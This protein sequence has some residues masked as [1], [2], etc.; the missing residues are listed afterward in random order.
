M[1][2]A[3]K[4]GEATE[5]DASSPASAFSVFIMMEDLIDKLKLL[6]YESQFVK[7]FNTKLLSK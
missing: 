4:A 1:D 3:K 5:D 2:K 7:E 6:G